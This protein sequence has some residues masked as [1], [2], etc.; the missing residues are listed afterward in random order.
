MSAK[1]GAVGQ[2][3]VV[4]LVNYNFQLH[5]KTGKWNVEADALAWIP[6][7]KVRSECQ[8]LDCLTVKAIIGGY[9]TDTL[10]IE[11]YVRKTDFLQNDTLFCSKVEIERNP[12]ITYQ[13]WQAAESR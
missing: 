9:T 6:W 8:D 1:L 3:W 5:Y 7:Q 4:A 13:E 11:A 2:C 10:L 12:T